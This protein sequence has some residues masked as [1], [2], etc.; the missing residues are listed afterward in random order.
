VNKPPG[1]SFHFIFGETGNH[2]T[3]PEAIQCAEHDLG[4]LRG[5]FTQPEIRFEATIERVPA[6][7]DN[8]E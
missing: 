8:H 5:R 7:R 1:T 4:Q 6:W 2:D 3:E